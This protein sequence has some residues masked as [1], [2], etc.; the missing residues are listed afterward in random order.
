MAYQK[1]W[2]LTMHQNFVMILIHGWKK[3][4]CKLYK[5]PP[6]HPQSNGLAKRMMQTVKMGLK[7]CS[8]QKGKKK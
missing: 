8:Q 7:V 2:Y 3:I 5:T 6:Y 4:G 1:P